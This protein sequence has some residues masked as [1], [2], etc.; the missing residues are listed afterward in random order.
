MN[1]IDL[2]QVCT[3][4]GADMKK[5][6][7]ETE[8]KFNQTLDS[9]ERVSAKYTFPFGFGISIEPQNEKMEAWELALKNACFLL[10]HLN[11]AVIVDK[12]FYNIPQAG[13]RLRELGYVPVKR[14]I[15]S[16]KNDGGDEF[17]EHMHESIL[18]AIRAGNHPGKKSVDPRLT[19]IVSNISH[20][21][22]PRL[23]TFGTFI[24]GVKNGYDEDEF[25]DNSPVL[26]FYRSNP[27]RVEQK[28]E[29]ICLNLHKSRA[30][31]L[32]SNILKGD[33]EMHIPMIDFECNMEKARS[34]AQKIGMPG[35]IIASGN[36]Y[37][38][39][40]FSLL[41]HEKNVNFLNSIKNLDGVD[42]GWTYYQLKRGYSNL[43]ITPALG[44]FSQP[45][46]V[47]NIP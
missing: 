10:P 9:G 46:F 30:V 36:S 19:E 37:H 5:L 2:T 47:E 23:L 8:Y 3:Y 14:T 39:Y 15:P 32:T 17:I 18:D 43:R 40:G 45:C 27:R 4:P 1:R 41:S 12:R 24:P 25:H 13:K 20:H 35:A 7:K 38:F 29:E 44:K 28:M 21:L 22:H 6:I 26:Q 11:L 42:T 34:I 33:D 31:G 16:L